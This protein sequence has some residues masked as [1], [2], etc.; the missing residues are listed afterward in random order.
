MHKHTKHSAALALTGLFCLL[1]ACDDTS[2]ADPGMLRVTMYGEEFI[3]D[4]VPADEMVDGWEVVFSKFLVAAQD[5][6]A[7]GTALSGTYVLDLRPSSGGEGHDVGMLELPAGAV[8]AIEYRVAP[9]TAGA[10]GNASDADIAEMV[11]A[12]SSIR[13]VGTAT[14][15]DVTITFDWSFST[16]THYTACET[17]A[18]VPEGGEG[19]SQLTIHSD[20]LFYD[21]LESEEPNVAF[22]I[23]ASADAD[24]DGTVTSEELAGVDITGESRYQVGSRGITDLWSY[25]EAQTETLGHIDGEGHCETHGHD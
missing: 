6:K 11:A 15:G 25:I 1:P 5:I 13:A 24:G 19:L 20:H 18:E 7:D 17:S 10:T 9:A 21:D 4:R 3:E 22:D 12:G 2:D 16:D 8:G 14:K 23:I